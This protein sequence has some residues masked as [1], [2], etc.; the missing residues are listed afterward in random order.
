MRD[1]YEILG[2]ERDADQREIKSAYRKIAVRFHPDRNPGNAE[3]ETK[4]KEAAEAYSVL[5]DPEKRRRYNRF[6]HQG[7]SG[8][9]GF[10]GFDPE[11]FGD[12]ADI[13]GDFFGFGDLFGGRT[14]SGRQARPGADL[15][16]ELTVTLEQA[17]FGTEKT[18]KIPRLEVC[19]DCFGSGSAEGS[20]PDVCTA[21][22]GQGQVRFSQGFF[23]VA[24][25][26]PQCGGEGT[27]I[28][29]PCPGCEGQARVERERT[30]QVKIPGGVDTGSRLRLAGE[31]EHGLR[32]GSTGDLYVDILVEPHSEFERHGPNVVSRM[33]LSY[34]Q[35]VLGTR[36][37]I[38]T[39]HG[40]V[41]VDIPP[42]TPHGGEFRLRGKGVEQIG[43]GGAGDH[44]LLVSLKVPH[45]RELD[46]Q[47][48]ELVRRLAEL[49]GEET[50]EERGV[51]NKVRDLFG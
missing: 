13:L 11:T 37:E 47:R 4:F 30:V 27:V 33:D 18:L 9:G 12:F 15:R 41:S 48:V 44:V 39:L 51:L 31:G 45:P 49:D 7:V 3:A 32:G 6:G 10:S 24:R 17:A 5:S 35:A 23:T 46:E 43:G 28:R 21:C 40:A 50:R 20:E 16:Y 34:S 36:V 26:C 19:P 22:R 8:G 38:A 25:T 1:Y 29:N 42:G 2:I 14:R